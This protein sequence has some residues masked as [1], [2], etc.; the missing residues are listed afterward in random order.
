MKFEIRCLQASMARK[1]M[2]EERAI[3][4]FLCVKLLYTV[5]FIAIFLMYILIINTERRRYGYCKEKND[6]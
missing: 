3:A 2:N 4:L 1:I 5:E 6:C